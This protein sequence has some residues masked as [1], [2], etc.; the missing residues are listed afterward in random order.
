MLLPVSMQM[1]QRNMVVLVA[2]IVMM[3]YVRNVKE[4][5]MKSTHCC[6]VGVVKFPEVFGHANYLVNWQ[7]TLYIVY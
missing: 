2:V 5:T 1:L 3:E 6:C 7:L 4:N